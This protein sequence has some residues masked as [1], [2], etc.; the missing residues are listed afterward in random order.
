[1]NRA[2]RGAIL[3][4]TLMMALLAAIVAYT[5]LQLAVSQ[6]RQGRFF[7]TQTTA[8]YLAEAGMVFAYERLREEPDYCP[9]PTAPV[10]V[11]TDGDQVGDA[12]VTIVVTN[13]GAGNVHEIQ[14]TAAN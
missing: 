6:G 8:R 1:M 4:V 14:V 10:L 7:R 12:P 5:V 9:D 13:C 2:D 3:A 11:D